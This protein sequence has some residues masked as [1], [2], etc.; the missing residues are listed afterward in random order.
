MLQIPKSSVEGSLLIG[1]VL[2]PNE[3]EGFL[4]VFGGVFLKDTKSVICK[5]GTL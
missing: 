1:V 5:R 3:A 4:E 2:F